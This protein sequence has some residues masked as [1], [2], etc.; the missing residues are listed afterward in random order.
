MVSSDGTIILS[1]AGKVQFVRPAADVLFVT[2]AIAYRERAIGVILTGSGQDGAIGALAVK[3]GGR[4]NDCT[5]G[6]GV[7]EYAGCR[8][9]HR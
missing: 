5:G 3:K 8:N 6:P 2:M 9:N 7:P 4:E 1:S